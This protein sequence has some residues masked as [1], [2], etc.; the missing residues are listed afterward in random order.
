[1][2]TLQAEGQNTSGPVASRQLLIEGYM[3][4]LCIA[5]SSLLRGIEAGLQYSDPGSLD[6]D[7]Y[8]RSTVLL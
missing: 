6:G 7:F 1:M 8:L 2:R 3:Y 4:R 5:L